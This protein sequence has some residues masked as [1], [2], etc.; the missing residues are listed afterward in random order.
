MAI[1]ITF[2]VIVVLWGVW[3]FYRGFFTQA[4]A[5]AALALSLAGAEPA[6]EWARDRLGFSMAD[7][8]FRDGVW[9]FLM[10][11]AL[12]LGLLIIGRMLEILLVERWSLMLASNRMLGGALGLVKGLVLTVGLAF[13]GLYLASRPE[14]RITWEA[15]LKDSQVRQILEPISPFNLVF[16]G[17]LQPW[18]PSTPGGSARPLP[19]DL[20]LPLL[21]TLVRDDNFV[22]AV[23]ARDYSGILLNPNFV[24]AMSS[25]DVRRRL[26]NRR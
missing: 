8:L 17:R 16:V 15:D 7:S 21:Q 12:Y 9:R 5:S 18:L 23:I 20:D 19:E 13:V 1:D 2:L 24:D 10:G 3:G 22:R 26:E 14:Y 11:L 25:D 4:W 6:L